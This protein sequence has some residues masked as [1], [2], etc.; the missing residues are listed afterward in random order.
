V[1]SEANL[2]GTR[3]GNY[4]LQKVIGRGHMGVVYLAIDEALLRPTAVKVLSNSMPEHDVKAWFL[5]EARSVAKLNHASVIQIYSVA[6]HG[7]HRYIAM[8][9]V[10]GASADVVVARQGRFSPEQATSVILQLAGALELA[11]TSGIIHRDVKPANILIKSDGTAKLGDFGMAISRTDHQANT[12]AGTPHYFAPEIW[13]GEP[14]SIASDLYALGATYYHL[15]S[16]R[17]PFVA[18]S[19]AELGVA[20]QHR[21]VP[22]LAELPPAVAATCMRLV[23][24]CMARNAS[25][26]P[27]SAQAVAWEARGVLRDLESATRKRRGSAGASGD[28]AGALRA[29]GQEWKALGFEHEP[30]G[31]IDSMDPPHRDALFDEARGGLRGQLAPGNAILLRGAA[32]SGR[33]ALA[34][35]VLSGWSGERRYL[36]LDGDDLRGDSLIERVT[37]AF[38][39]VVRS[40]AT[41]DATLEGLLEVLAAPPKKAPLAEQ[42]PL[43]VLDGVRAGSRAAAELAQLA[44]AA[45]STHYFSLL[46]IGDAALAGEVFDPTGAV[47]E[48]SPLP[49]ARVP[50][51]LAS[52]LRATLRQDARALMVTMDAAMLLGVRSSGNLRKLNALARRMLLSKPRAI[53]TSW[54]AAIATDD[55]SGEAALIPQRPTAWPTPEILQLLNQA[56]RSAGVAERSPPISIER[57]DFDEL[58]EDD[59]GGGGASAATAAQASGEPDD[60]YF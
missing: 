25:D 45:R 60:D 35:S 47:F 21:E 52:W 1:S 16:G 31:E 40:G 24:L 59:A 5:S 8:E 49:L 33:T 19:I 46:V 42:V 23:K 4:S 34:R 17:P 37:R 14:A 50:A 48:L 3:L 2:A 12:R 29:A 38:G 20:H 32:G 15:L 7:P 28:S 43:V 18:D 57:R 9:Y 6:R 13:R 11:H 44:R 36:A 10:E 54:E 56:R 51:Y 41:G 39:A 27:R 58:S 53:F 55:V 26:R 22:P 30:F